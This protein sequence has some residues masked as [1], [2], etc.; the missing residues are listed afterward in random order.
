MKKVVTITTTLLVVIAVA[1]AGWWFLTKPKDT[2][3]Q[4]STVTYL[5]IKELGIKMEVP[6]EIGD[7]VYS[8]DTTNPK[9]KTARLS[10]QTLIDRS[11]GSCT[12]EASSLGTVSATQD[13]NVNVTSPL[14]PNGK[15]I[16]KLNNTYIYIEHPQATCS[17]D[18]AIQTLQ[19]KQITAL[20]DA[21]KTVQTDE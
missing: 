9:V 19:T 12:S 1:G 10:T 6:E 17:N 15:T 8:I 16:F 2:N 5:R 14:E 21:F 20:F 18:P 4:N 13:P 3:Q 7:I 11:S